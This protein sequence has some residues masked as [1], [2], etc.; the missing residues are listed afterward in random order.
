MTFLGI[1]ACQIGTAM[2]A[3]A[4]RT[5]LARIGFTTN[6]MLLWGIAFEIL[7]AAVVVTIPPFQ[8]VFGTE[9][10]DL[11]LLTLLI[12]LPFIVWGSDEIFRWW[13]RTHD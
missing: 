13:L 1:V 6:R 7:F 2:A 9:V 3:R 12:P 5:S 10:P 4:S 8:V 11:W